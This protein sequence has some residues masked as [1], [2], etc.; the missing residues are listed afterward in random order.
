MVLR[1]GEIRGL[2][3]IFEHAPQ[4]LSVIVHNQKYVLKIILVI[5]NDNV[6]Q[7]SSE[8][9][10][11]HLTQILHDLNFTNNFL[12]L[13]GGTE[14]FG[15][16]FYGHH[17]L[18]FFVVGLE[19]TSKWSLSNFSMY[20]VVFSDGCEFIEKLCCTFVHK[21]NLKLFIIKVTLIPIRIKILRGI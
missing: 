12:K 19:H 4:V 14:N 9:V 6:I 13:I 2:L 18:S 7:M 3:L 8:N 5:W 10:W 1:E 15:N 20:F 11:F 21:F 16:P 17:F